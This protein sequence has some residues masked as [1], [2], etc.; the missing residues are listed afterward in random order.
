MNTFCDEFTAT[1]RADGCDVAR[2]PDGRI[3]AIVLPTGGAIA[4]RMPAHVAPTDREAILGIRAARILT[5][6]AALVAKVQSDERLSDAAK[7]EDVAKIDDEAR[8][9]FAQVKSEADALI[10]EFDDA[11][12]RESVPPPLAPGDSVGALLDREDRDEVRKLDREGQTELAKALLDGKHPDILAS[13]L[14]S[15]WP[16]PPVLAAVVNEAYQR[17]LLASDPQGARLR[18]RAV[19]R[20]DWLRGITGQTFDAMPRATETLAQARN[21][22]IA[23]RT[24]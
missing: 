6:R 16:L 11:D 13:L 20:V 9:S 18:K 21:N 14:R 4:W 1:I 5:K 12:A 8:A 15:R 22:E 3:D 10:A 24:D 2:A 23:K 17:Q 19:D 7:I